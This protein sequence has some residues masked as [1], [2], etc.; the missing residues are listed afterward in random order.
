MGSVDR[1][2][3]SS[4]VDRTED[5]REWVML[6]LTTALTVVPLLG[7]LSAAMFCYRP[8]FFKLGRAAV[9]A[10]AGPPAPTRPQHGQP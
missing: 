7:G 5:S 6:S 3:L 1:G 8:R 9:P 10:A 2:D 4:V